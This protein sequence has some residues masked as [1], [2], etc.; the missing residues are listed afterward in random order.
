MLLAPIVLFGDWRLLR[1]AAIIGASLVVASFA[2]GPGLWLEWPRALAGFADVVPKTNRINPSALFASPLWAAA[3]AQLGLLIAW[4]WRDLAGLVGG[5][6]CVTPY[7]HQ[8]DLAPLA[9]LAL[10]WLIEARREGL[11]RAA[12]GAG[13]LAG[14]IATPLL[15]LGVAGA[16][17]IVAKP[18]RIGA[19]A[20]PEPAP[21]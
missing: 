21:P 3:T 15:G 11:G 12:T 2:F 17:A 10:A 20:A 1:W 16:L 9:P 7:A 5:A 14:L 4:R 19:A 13:L 8:Y 18:L 6:L